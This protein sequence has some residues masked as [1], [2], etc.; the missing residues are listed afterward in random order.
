[1][2]VAVLVAR[3]DTM[4]AVEGHQFDFKLS[5]CRYILRDNFVEVLLHEFKDE[6]QAVL[7]SDDFFQ[8]YD[9]VM[10]ELAE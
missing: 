1:M 2:E 8:F 7:L 3:L 4:Q 9:V 10:V 5:R 6:I